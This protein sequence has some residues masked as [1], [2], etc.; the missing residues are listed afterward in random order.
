ML[1]S[2][3]DKVVD[4]ASHKQAA[5]LDAWLVLTN[6][7]DSLQRGLI[8]DPFNDGYRPVLQR[9]GQT[10]HPSALDLLAGYLWRPA[11]PKSVQRIVAERTEPELAIAI[12]RS[13]D[14][15]SALFS[16]QK[17]RDMPPLACFANIEAELKSCSPEIRRRLWLMLAAT[18]E[19]PSYSL[20]LAIRVSKSGTAEARATAADMIRVC[21]RVELEKLVFAMQKS[22]TVN[23][24]STF[25]D[26]LEQIALWVSSPSTVLQKAAREFFEEFTLSR[27][28]DQIRRW[29]SPLCKAM[30]RIVRLTESDLPKKL[31]V[32]MQSPAPKRR[33]AG[34]QATQLLDLS[35]E[36]SEELLP[37]VDDSR[38]EV[39]V[40]VIDLLSALGH[41]ALEETLPRL[42]NDASTDIQEAAA[43]AIKRFNKRK[44]KFASNSIPTEE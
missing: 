4:F 26:A 20:N 34:I 8:S 24:G 42:L 2:L 44:T 37:L 35:R 7:D 25:A 3:Y 1:Q 13:L 14:N 15:K 9:I 32:E 39:R 43:R 33:I 30:A 18:S 38:L 27:L 19:D 5:I 28:L 21:R 11:T 31:T 17:L 6:W 29:P 22:T 12:A 41:E 36:V 10:T 40:R 16:I 23:G